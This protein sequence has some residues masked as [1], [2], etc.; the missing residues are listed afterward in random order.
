MK[1]ITIGFSR[2]STAFPIFSWLIMAVQR[3]PYSHVYVKYTDPNL[4]RTIVYQASHTLVNYMSEATFSAQETIVKEFTFNVSDAS[5]LTFQQ[6][7]I[8]NAGKPYGVEEI[9]GLGLV[10]IALAFNIKMHNP[11]KEAGSTWVCDQLVAAILSTCEQIA[12]PMPLNDMTPK[13][14]YALVSTLPSVLSTDV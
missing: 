9:F 12:L 8:D 6:F 11:L 5:F 13:D 3:T 1:Q 14:V 10:E 2:A 7:A 4:Q